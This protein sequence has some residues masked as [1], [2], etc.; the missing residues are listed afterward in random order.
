[1][2]PKQIAEEFKIRC[3]KLLGKELEMLIWGSVKKEKYVEGKSDI[4]IMLFAKEGTIGWDEWLKIVKSPLFKDM[5]SKGKKY[6]RKRKRPLIDLM[7]SSP[8]AQI[9]WKRELKK[10]GLL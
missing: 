2:N 10:R 6:D 3:E 5:A 8:K 7:F 9:N 4:D 1:M